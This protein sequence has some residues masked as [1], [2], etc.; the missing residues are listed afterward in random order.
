MAVEQV[1]KAGRNDGQPVFV[2][3]RAMAKHPACGGSV[4]F[5]ET[6]EKPVQLQAPDRQEKASRTVEKLVGVQHLHG[7][8]GG[9]S[10]QGQVVEGKAVAECIGRK[11]W[12]DHAAF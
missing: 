12:R 8:T 1:V 10:G 4:G 5:V 6:V 9:D 2:G 3:R 7:V 11:G